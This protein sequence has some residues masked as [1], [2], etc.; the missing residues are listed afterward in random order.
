MGITTI[1]NF[2]TLHSGEIKVGEIKKTNQQLVDELQLSPENNFS[3]TAMIGAIAAKQAV[4]NAQIYSI[5]MEGRESL[6]QNTPGEMN[7]YLQLYLLTYE[8][9]I[10]TDGGFYRLRPGHCHA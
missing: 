7:F 10:G 2:S 8:D 9:A 3:R 1:D 4:Q 6:Q 5:F